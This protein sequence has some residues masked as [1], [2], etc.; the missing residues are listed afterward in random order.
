MKVKREVHF[1]D[2][3]EEKIIEDLKRTNIRINY[4]YV[5]ED[6]NVR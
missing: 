1:D 5:F 2:L 6:V 3:I 4:S